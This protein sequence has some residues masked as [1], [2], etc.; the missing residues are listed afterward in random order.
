MLNIKMTGIDARSLRKAAYAEVERTI[1][2]RA[3]AAAR[4][5]GGVKVRFARNMDGSLRSVSFEGSNAAVEA[6]T[7]ATGGKK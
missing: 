4:A 5:H 6:A 2:S 7:H 1:L 3:T